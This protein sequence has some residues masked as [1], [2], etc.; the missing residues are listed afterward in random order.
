MVVPSMSRCRY[1]RIKNTSLVVQVV[2]RGAQNSLLHRRVDNSSVDMSVEFMRYIWCKVRSSQDKNFMHAM[3][4]TLYGKKTKTNKQKVTAI[5]KKN[6]KLIPSARGQMRSP[7]VRV[8]SGM[9][10]LKASA[11][12]L[13]CTKTLGRTQPMIAES[14]RFPPMQRKK[15]GS[16]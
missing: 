13:R 1:D 3:C 6:K 12:K 16:S 8:N 7:V 14:Y 4:D 2:R 10:R 5:Q 15:V 9:D 11:A